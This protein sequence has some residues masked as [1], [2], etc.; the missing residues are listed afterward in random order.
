MPTSPT[1]L[2]AESN[3]EWMPSACM[4]ADP[5]TAPYTYFA[6]ATARFSTSTIHSTRR[7]DRMRVETA[8]LAASAFAMLD[9][10]ASSRQGPEYEK[11][12]PLGL[13]F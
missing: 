7:I 13:S 9:S 1:T 8:S 5:V 4:D 11:G 12:E 3:T 2:P 6:A 10:S